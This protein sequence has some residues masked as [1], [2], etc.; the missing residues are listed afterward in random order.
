MWIYIHKLKGRMANWSSNKTIV[1]IVGIG[2][3]K[4]LFPNLNTSE[5]LTLKSRLAA[6]N[7]IVSDEDLDLFLRMYQRSFVWFLIGEISFVGLL[8]IAAQHLKT[9]S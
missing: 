5:R 6:P 8:A 2:R 7:E 1:F 4:T 9:I 3:N